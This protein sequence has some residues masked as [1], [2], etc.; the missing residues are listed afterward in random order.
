[1]RVEEPLPYARSVPVVATF[2]ENVCYR[3]A[4]FL[5]ALL[6]PFPCLLDPVA[7][8][9]DR[10]DF[11]AMHLPV[12][13]RDDA[14]GVRKHLRPSANGRFVVTTVLAAPYLRLISSNSR[15]AWRFE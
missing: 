3:R 2:Y 10:D 5:C 15:S 9:F 7:L 6:G 14:G 4:A 8:A 1:M 11:G 12:N 13:Q